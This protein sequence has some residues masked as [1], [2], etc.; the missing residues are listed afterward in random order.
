MLFDIWRFNTCAV[1]VLDAKYHLKDETVSSYLR[2]N[3]YS[4]AFQYN[5]LIPLVSS[6][7]IHDPG[8]ASASLPIVML[9]RYLWNHQ[10]LHTFE[11]S[12]DWLVIKGGATKYVDAILKKTP[13]ERLHRSAPVR[14]IHRTKNGLSL[15]LEDGSVQQF[16]KV[17]LAT[18]APEALK[19]LGDHATSDERQ[20][21]GDF[22]T[23]PSR[24][25]L[26]SDTSVGD[27]HQHGATQLTSS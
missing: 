16:D 14:Q 10:L 4:T 2:R 27:H 6:V 17:I 24:V 7:W 3:K 8:D 1:R 26:H 19:M 12:F 13:S 5:Y 18:H 20:I 23:S 15:E 21:L 11:S 9:V 22:R 25:V